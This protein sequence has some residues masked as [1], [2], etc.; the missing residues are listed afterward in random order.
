MGKSAA[1]AHSFGM[2]NGGFGGGGGS[3]GGNPDQWAINAYAD[4]NDGDN[5]VIPS[6]YRRMGM[7]AAD[8]Q[9]E[10][11]RIGEAASARNTRRYD[12]YGNRV[13]G[14]P[15]D[16][17]AAGVQ[18]MGG[19]QGLSQGGGYN[20]MAQA[21]PYGG[22]QLPSWLGGQMGYGGGPNHLTS[23]MGQ[24][25]QMGY[26]GGY[27]QQQGGGYRGG[28]G[29]GFR[30][31]QQGY[32]GGYGQQQQRGMGFNNYTQQY[33]FPTANLQSIAKQLGANSY[34][35]N[36]G[37]SFVQG[38]LNSKKGDSNYDAFSDFN[39]DGMVTTL[40]FAEYRKANPAGSMVES[41][42]SRDGKMDQMRSMQEAMGKLQ[43]SM[44]GYNQGIGG[45]G[46][47][48]GQQG[49]GGYGGG[50]GGGY[51]KDGGLIR[52][53]QD[54]G[55]MGGAMGGGIMDEVASMMSD[56]MSSMPP[57]AVQGSE[58]LT[59][60]MEAKAALEGNHPDPQAAL[61]AFV[62]VFGE[63]ELMSLKDYV[64]QTIQTGEDRFADI[65]MGDMM[66]DGMSD[67]IPGN[68]DGMEQVAL[69]EG[70]YVVPADVVSGMGNGDT[71][72]G[73]QRMREMVEM[74][75]SARTGMPEQPPA[76][77]PSMYYPM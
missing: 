24:S 18:D 36:T 30:G 3:R 29:G 5:A 13:T 47:Y 12:G 42:T 67:S 6:K 75:R 68:I 40:D 33:N 65:P 8:F 74:V 46:G 63:K 77:D 19:Q 17:S 38:S 61:Q 39:N 41:Q 27:G 28:Y 34:V 21:N 66:N 37:N 10:I 45:Y 54:G 23:L 11:Q 51:Y 70:E 59:I 72:S 31:Q 35:P 7:T 4:Q 69:S 71:N 9:S 1:R 48:G 15:T 73:A 44:G 32:G 60:V 22:Q 64:V 26:G 49:Y 16:P 2:S 25:Q 62:E 50:Y 53:Y 14:A 43:S 20:Q 56:P 52:G 55:A 76:I 58:M 57:E